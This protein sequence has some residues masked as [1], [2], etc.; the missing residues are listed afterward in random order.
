MK[1]YV[2]SLAMCILIL[3]PQGCGNMSN[4]GKDAIIGGGA[5]AALGAAVGAMISKDGKGAAI[6]AAIG[7]SLGAG[8]GAIIGRKMDKKAEEL[9]AQLEQAEVETVED[10][11][12]LEA[13]KVTFGSGILFPT[14]GTTLSRASE[15]QLTDFAYQMQ[16]LPDTDIS[17]FGHT[18]NTGTAEVNERISNQRADAVSTFLKGRGI[19]A[20]RITA[21]GKSFNEPVADNGTKEGRAQNRR[22]EI[23]IYANE[24]MVEAANNGTLE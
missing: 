18:D 6:G 9:A 12:G 24:A 23:Y 17:I 21:E 19:A 20:E 1:K 4:T 5:G 15:K 3:V 11:N 16:D 14:N 22:V 10:S 8:T 7:S 2:I 13:I